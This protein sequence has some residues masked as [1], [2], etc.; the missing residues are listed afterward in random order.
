MRTFNQRMCNCCYEAKQDRAFYG[1]N[2][3]CKE[4][5]AKGL[6]VVELPIVSAPPSSYT[7]L[8]AFK[9]IIPRNLLNIARY[10]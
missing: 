8:P 6:K 1:K 4:C 3:V 5:K 9:Y 7:F 10:L 2:T